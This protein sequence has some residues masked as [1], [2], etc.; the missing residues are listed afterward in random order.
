[1]STATGRVQWIDITKGLAIVL[2]VLVHYNQ[3]FQSPVPLLSQISYIG[4][5]GPQLFFIIS[6]FLTWISLS[7]VKE[8]STKNY[9]NFVG[10][11]L[12]RILPE[13]YLALLLAVLSFCV[14]LGYPKELTWGGYI[15]H[16]LLVNGF[17]PKHINSILIVEWYVS[18]LIIFYILAPFI[19]KTVCNLKQSIVLLIVCIIIS[20]LFHYLTNDIS[21]YKDYYSTICIIVQ[22]PVIALGIVLYYLCN[23][24]FTI[25]L[26]QYTVVSLAFAFTGGFL[27]SLFYFWGCISKSLLAGFLFGWFCYTIAFVEK[28][29][30]VIN[31]RL[32][33]I[34]GR[35]SLG[36]YLFHMFIIK[37]LGVVQITSVINKSLIGWALVFVLTLT[38]SIIISYYTNKLTT[39]KGL[40]YVYR[41]SA[42]D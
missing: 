7:K 3:E 10:G 42:M 26:K 19:K 38:L 24:N 39:G 35:Y 20:V 4:A 23:G 30:W 36:I 13:Y 9:F 8:L 14:G 6:G 11:R 25:S 15:S 32:L 40:F 18:D 21:E 29:G 31:L 2:V 16:F 12:R 22:M 33:T 28:K 34:L 37:L 27:F 5:R 17:S 41:K 1:M